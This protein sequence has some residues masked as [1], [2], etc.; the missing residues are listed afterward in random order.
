[1]G[2]RLANLAERFGVSPQRLAEANGL[3]AD[4]ILMP[5]TVLLVPE[6]ARDAGRDRPLGPL[7][8]SHPAQAGPGER[9]VF[10][11]TAFGDDLATLGAAFGLSE[12]ELVR[13][14]AIDPRARL[15][16][17]M[18][19][20]VVVGRDL[21]LSHV[22]HFELSDVP[23]LAVL[24]AGS[25]EFAEHFEGIKG[26]KRVEILAK[27]GDT[28]ALIGKR[29]GMSVGSMERI[30]QRS[31]STAIVPGERVVVYTERTAGAAP[32]LSPGVLPPLEVPRPDLLPTLLS[33][34]QPV[35]SEASAH[36]ASVRPPSPLSE[37][38]SP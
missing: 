19:L 11:E 32:A 30:N 18:V 12:A 5:K 24:V 25:P 28:L 16:E 31:R 9:V 20:Q 13:D 17:G 15:A 14:S 3:G 22:R 29:H 38:Q 1:V 23:A 10:Y 4:V 21:D 6:G 33:A 35:D 34:S 8:V 7:V 26:K 2:D 37:S 27:P 36:P